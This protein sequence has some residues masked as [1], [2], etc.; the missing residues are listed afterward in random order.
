MITTLLHM[1]FSS[2]S[3]P[4]QASSDICLVPTPWWYSLQDAY[5]YIK[6]YAPYDNL[7]LDNTRETNTST[8]EAAAAAAG[9]S[10]SKGGGMDA[11]GGHEGDPAA[12]AARRSP[13]APPSV[14]PYPAMLLTASLHDH[15]VNYWEPLKWVAALRDLRA[16]IRQQQAGQPPAVI[17]AGSD[18]R[19]S[20]QPGHQEDP[21]MGD[22]S[23]S[24][25][26]VGGNAGFQGGCAGGRTTNG[27]GGGAAL[28]LPPL[29]LL[30]DLEAGHF[31]A[32][33]ASDRLQQK[34]L[35]MAFL[36][37]CLGVEC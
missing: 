24:H 28:L 12:S 31:A 14:Y 26:V 33:G 9:I 37:R 23:V 3:C 13:P 4:L 32:S 35:K 21:G 5:R 18:A 6:T 10:S 20:D 7:H 19:G 8:A 2:S 11:A 17:A 22:A 36:M 1:H 16:R 34:A 30:T 25:G 27:G 15:R 29:L